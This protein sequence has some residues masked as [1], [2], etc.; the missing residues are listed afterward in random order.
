LVAASR[1]LHSI[2]ADNPAIGASGFL[3]RNCVLSAIQD[4]SRALCDCERAILG[5]KAI[6][7]TVC[8][9]LCRR[10]S[11]ASRES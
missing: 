4:G 5:A 9:S 1:S 6:A 8:Y 10:V 2:V 3:V 11:G 7:R